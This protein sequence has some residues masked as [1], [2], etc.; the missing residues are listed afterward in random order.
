[1]PAN[2]SVRVRIEKHVRSKRETARKT[3]RARDILID[4]TNL[5]ISYSSPV[6]CARTANIV[7]LSCPRSPVARNEIDRYC[8]RA[9]SLF[10]SQ[11]AF[12]S[13]PTYVS[14]SLDM[15]SST[16]PTPRGYGSF[17][18]NGHIIMSRANHFL[19]SGR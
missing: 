11:C 4:R 3:I 19:L 6:C 9:F 8:V 15:S 2:R 17:D 5:I 7:V 18:K 1:M 13:V 14:F 16:V 12:V 10:H